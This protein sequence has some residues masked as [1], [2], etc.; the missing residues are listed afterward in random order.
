M[1][2]HIFVLD[3]HVS[4]AFES[5]IDDNDFALHQLKTS[6]THCTRVIFQLRIQPIV[7]HCLDEIKTSIE[8]SLFELVSLNIV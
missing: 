4:R 5:I 7:L 2:N 8:P 3:D 1:C 6:V